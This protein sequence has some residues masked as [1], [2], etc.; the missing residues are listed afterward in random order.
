PRQVAFELT[1]GMELPLRAGGVLPECRLG[2]APVARGA[3]DVRLELLQRKDRNP[4][5]AAPFLRLSQP[6]G[7]MLHAA[8]AIEL[9][10]PNDLVGD[11]GAPDDHE[12]RTSAHVRWLILHGNSSECHRSF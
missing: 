5:D 12:P 1:L 7:A 4:V 11:A 8:G 6:V 9:P 2:I 10:G 3:F